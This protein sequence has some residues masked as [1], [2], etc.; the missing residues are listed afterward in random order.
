MLRHT[1]EL[2]DRNHDGELDFIERW[3]RDEFEEEM[4]RENS[5]G[6]SD[7]DED[8]DDDLF[9]EDDDFDEDEDGD[10]DFDVDDF[11]NSSVAGSYLKMFLKS[12]IP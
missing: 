9:D 1:D 2:F 12:E 4:I 3:Q 10:D 11:W 5:G 6:Y 7:D 8:E